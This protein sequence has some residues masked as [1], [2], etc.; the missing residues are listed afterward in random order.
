MAAQ[1]VVQV[2]RDSATN[3]NGSQLLVLYGLRNLL[4]PV[5]LWS[6]FVRK[7]NLILHHFLYTHQLFSYILQET[8][9]ISQQSLP[10]A[11]TDGQGKVLFDFIRPRGLSI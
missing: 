7:L 9:L 6:L 8:C 10:L 2:L 4:E 3:S 5:D 1:H 11:T